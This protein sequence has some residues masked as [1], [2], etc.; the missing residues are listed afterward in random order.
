[1]VIGKIMTLSPSDLDEDYQSVQRSVELLQRN[2]AVTGGSFSIPKYS[3]LWN[4]S[5]SSLPQ[6]YDTNQLL[7]VETSRI[8][9]Q[10][11]LI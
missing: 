8:L 4:T 6:Y 10:H 7:A 3:E 9:L 5:T 2:C 1:M 11:T